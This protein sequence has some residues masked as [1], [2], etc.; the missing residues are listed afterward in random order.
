MTT[1]KTYTS[2][3]IIEYLATV[4]YYLRR[5]T[6]NDVAHSLSLNEVTDVGFHWPLWA[7]KNQMPSDDAWHIWLLLAG[8]GFGKT[9]TGAEWVRARVE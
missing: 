4:P 3:K 6:F 8:R 5:A 9:R 7:R 1:D 2:E